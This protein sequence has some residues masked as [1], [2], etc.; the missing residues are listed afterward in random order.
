MTE[1]MPAKMLALGHQRQ[2]DCGW[3]DEL[4]VHRLTPHR[5]FALQCRSG[6]AKILVL[7][8]SGLLA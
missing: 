7:A 3:L 2:L 8:V 5:L 6:E 4:G 1:A